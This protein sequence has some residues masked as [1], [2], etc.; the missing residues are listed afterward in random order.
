MKHQNFPRSTKAK[1]RDPNP[2][3]DEHRIAASVR[4][5]HPAPET[6]HKK[7][8]A[9]RIFY[10]DLPCNKRSQA[11]ESDIKTLGGTVEKFFSKD[12]RYLVSSKPEARHVQRL[13]Q[14][15]P[16]PSPDSGLSSPHPGSRR[17][18]H[19]HRGSS[20]G[21]ADTVVVSRG[22]SL[23]EKVVKEQERVQMNRILANALEWGVK[24][25]YINDVISYIDK[26]KS[27]LA[28]VRAETH[29]VKKTVRL[30]PTD[31]TACQKGK[32]GCISH[33]FVKVE[34]FSRHYRPLYLPMAN[35]PVCNFRS[36]AP[37]S[38]FL[39]ANVRENPGKRAKVCGSG[40]DRRE[41]SRKDKQRGRDCKIRRKGGYCECCLV[42]Y[43][44]LSAHLQSEQ[45]QAFSKSEEYLVVD[46]IISGLTC[47]F[48]QINTELKRVKCS[49]TSPLIVPGA[50]V[51]KDEKIGGKEE[52]VTDETPLW[53]SPDIERSVRKRSR[54]LSQSPEGD[55]AG[56]S[57]TFQKFQSKC[58]S[59]S[60][61]ALQKVLC[62][63]LCNTRQDCHSE[64]LEA[65]RSLLNTHS[66]GRTSQSTRRIRLSDPSGFR[67]THGSLDAGTSHTVSEPSVHHTTQKPFCNLGQVTQHKLKNKDM[68]SSSTDNPSGV[69]QRKVRTMRRR[70]T[71]P[72]E[73]VFDSAVEPV[74]FQA[75]PCPGNFSE[76]PRLSATTLDLWQLFQSSDYMEEDFK[77][78]VLDKT[79][80]LRDDSR[81]LG[82]ER[83]VPVRLVYRT[84]NEQT[85]HDALSTRVRASPGTDQKNHVAQASF[86][87]KAFDRT[88][89]LD[90]EL[91]HD[92]LS[93]KYVERHIAKD[94]KSSVTKGGE[95]CYYH[96]TVRDIPG[97]FVALSTCHGMHGMFFDGNHT[98]LIEPNEESKN[99][100]HVQLHM[101]YKSPGFQAPGDFIPSIDL[102]ESPFQRP[103]LFTGAA[104]KRKKR[105]VLQNSHSVEDETKYIELMVINDHL[106]YK[107]HRLSVGQTN[108]YAKS[109]VN[110][111]DF[112]G[113]TEEMAITLAQSLGQNIGI[114][115]DKKRI[116]NGECKCDDKWSGCI[117][118]DVGFY[119]PKRFSDCNVEE[120][121][122]FL[123]SGGGSCLF[124][125]PFKLLDPPECGNSFVEP[126]E[127]C[128]CG[129][130]AMEF[131]GVICREAVNDCD[132][133]ENCTGNSSQCPPNVHKM[134]GYTCEKDQGR[135]FNGRCK[136][137]DR[138]CKYI[139]G[140]K[141]TS[142]DKFCYEK[143]NIEGT[144]KGNCGRDKDTWIQCKKQDVQCGYL[145]CSNISPAPRLGELQGGLTSGGHVMID[146][147]T[148][149][150]YVE[151]GTACGTDH[152]CFNHKC[153]PVQDF[154][155]STCPGTTDKIICSGHGVCSNELKCVCHLGWAGED[156]N[157][158]S[159][160]SYLVVGPTATSSAL[161]FTH[162]FFVTRLMSFAGVS[163]RNYRQQ[164]FTESE[165]HR[166]FC[167]QMPPGD[168]VKKPGDADSFYSDVP[169]G[170]SSNSG[171]SSKK[172]S[173][174]LS[175]LQ[176]YTSIPSISQNISQ[177][178]F[179]SNGLSHSWSERIP[180][181]K[182]ISDI[183]E[184]GRPR[185]NSWQGNISG[186]RRKLK[187][188]KF[189]PRSNSTETL[190]P[191]KSPTSSTGS[192]AS[193]RRYPYP[194]PPLPDEERKANRQNA[195]VRF[196]SYWKTP[197]I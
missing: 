156:C 88:F 45:H 112:Y 58:G 76:S 78:G 118:D 107:K 18:S 83:T 171:S 176:I 77:G 122:N 116:L 131:M 113:K 152:I 175:H 121:H 46:R 197:N 32:S 159:P 40:G 31:G 108:N 101:I 126:G 80:A 190:S 144:E 21:P 2:D 154:N 195:R 89:I 132:I 151:D 5:P 42:K 33:P 26:K 1:F 52:D 19:G 143:L 119:L 194:M 167:R 36:A 86:Q 137:K 179:R 85:P 47:D 129:T 61:A 37:C 35:L 13:V 180:D 91:N 66:E 172:R 70:R 8:L 188:K 185:S 127:E 94:G 53:G 115:S 124:N 130:P 103:P 81:F 48:V 104:H 97:S 184:N 90:L 12:I 111:A 63:S 166:R 43:D 186:N 54:E 30:E 114:F 178:A 59:S 123:Y 64:C 92:L 138:Q 165:V 15:S 24:I 174:Y 192:I 99:N 96:G 157:S 57:D 182:H 105:Q 11:L 191:A 162:S 153:L 173:A 22:K 67:T 150:G 170:V 161:I 17:D 65:T 134:D 16:V 69:L 84:G 196:R 87:V 160:L 74:E 142:A 34:D 3:N 193:S 44:D 136:T 98:Y 28:R 6:V 189:R 9:G 128:D 95:H 29:P 139:W 181:A 82:K 148:D 73:P 75:P 71:A 10:L 68:S 49:V 60:D 147:D 168:Y 55:S 56:Q 163:V 158:S 39:E 27:A 145:L 146:G 38:P 51:I 23:V 177:F 20:Q 110:M 187:G 135:C 50:A 25:L 149:L 102:A 133:P 125:K 141:A 41:K 4:N 100:E 93:S 164:Q 155:F 14:D 169:Q 72:S 79:R 183:C 117:M 140:E 109:V 106:M 120:Y 7:P 62:T